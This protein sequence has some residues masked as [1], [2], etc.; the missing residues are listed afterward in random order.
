MGNDVL[1][2]FVNDGIWALL[3]GILIFYIL[4]AQEK[5]DERQDDRDKEY[6]TVITNLSESLKCVEEIRKILKD[7]LK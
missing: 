3:S 2:Y 1:S 7:K 5:R 6:Q 4:R